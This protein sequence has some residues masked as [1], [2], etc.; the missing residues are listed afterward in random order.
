MNLRNATAWTLVGLFCGLVAQRAPAQ[1]LTTAEVEALRRNA[2]ARASGI[3][4][5]AAFDEESAARAVLDSLRSED[6]SARHALRADPGVVTPPPVPRNVSRHHGD[7]TEGLEA[8]GYAM[9]AESPEGFQPIEMAPVGEDYLLG[10]GDELVL[11]LWGDTESVQSLA[12]D[13]EG[14]AFV[15]DVG[16]VSLGGRRVDEARRELRARLSEVYSGLK[17]TDRGG[18]TTSLELSVAKLRTVQVFVL[19][20]VVRPG[21][22]RVASNASLLDLLYRAGGARE[23]GSL[24]SIRALRAGEPIATFDLYRALLAGDITANVRLESGDVVHV[25]PVGER[26]TVRGEVFRP[27]VYEILPGE[28]LNDVLAAAGGA[29]KR[30]YL[31]RASI[32]RIRDTQPKPGDRTFGWEVVT[33]GSAELTGESPFAVR[34]GDEVEIGAID[35]DTGGYVSIE[36]NGIV[37]PGRFEWKEGLTLTQVVGSAGLRPEASTKHVQIVRQRPDLVEEILS[38]SLETKGSNAAFLLQ[39]RDAISVRSIWDF[40]EPD[41][42][43]IA[44]PVRVPGRYPLREGLTLQDLLFMARGLREE[45]YVMVAEVAR[46]EDTA[47]E[48]ADPIVLSFPIENWDEP[49]SPAS[50]IL[51]EKHDA[52]FVRKHP[53]WELQQTV[54]VEGEVRFPG[55]Y[56]LSHRDERLS[57]LIERAGGL[58]PTAYASAAVFKRAHD[59]IGRVA[60]DLE[61]ALR[62]A[63]GV[64]DLA[65]I[66]GDSLLVPKIS[67]TVKVA[68]EVGLPS[69]VLYREGKGVGYYIDQAGGLTDFADED[70]ILVQR[71]SGEVQKGGGGWFGGGPRVDAGTSIIVP[72]KPKQEGTHSLKTLADIVGVLSG[73]A[74]TFFLIHEVSK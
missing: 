26:V 18:A 36:G 4:R 15:R 21:A 67:H 40:T 43:A 12:I 74:T 66:A 13:R 58:K 33:V 44:G 69:S 5:D 41:S 28:T 32:R 38:V 11:T 53:G 1:G 31:A 59:G 27:A 72:R 56:S 23:T 65:L 8:F 47:T 10:P 51:L 54:T 68:G 34:D 29:T 61:R 9:F 73:A 39:D 14:R 60:V 17:K 37:R 45:A 70:Q 57:E 16:L 20:E 46:V 35:P 63:G 19:G 3:E 25:P 6:V 55:V 22:Y 71:A 52:V 2:A 49:G 24:R 48:H 42:V 64:N 62:D 7:P 50:R 30:A